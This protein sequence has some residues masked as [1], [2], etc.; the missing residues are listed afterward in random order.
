VTG[1]ILRDGKKVVVTRMELQ[2]EEG[3]LIATGTGTYIV[4]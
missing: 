1:S 4:S 2:N 3:V